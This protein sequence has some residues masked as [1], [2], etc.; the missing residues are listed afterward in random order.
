MRKKSVVQTGP[1]THEGGFSAG[2]FSA[3]YQV[4][5]DGNVN[6]EPITPA[7]SDTAMAITNFK[8]LFIGANKFIQCH[9]EPV[10]SMDTTVF[11][12]QAQD[13]NIVYL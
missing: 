2:L 5:M 6:S 9:G 12:R 13:D 1:N 3:A 11:L 8:V 7:S 10:E 4:G